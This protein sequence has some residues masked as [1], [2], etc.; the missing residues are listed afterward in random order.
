MKI[1]VPKEN[2]P[3]E[4]RVAAT[5][6]TV[7]KMVAR[8]WE[9]WVE[10]GAGAKAHFLNQAYEEAGAQVATQPSGT[11]DAWSSAGAVLKVGPFDSEGDRLEDLSAGTLVI[12]LLAPYRELNMVRQL[13]AGR[14]TSLAMELVPRITRAQ[15]MDALSSQASIAGYKAALLAASRLDR[16]FPLLMTAA[17]TVPPARVVVMGGGVAGLQ[18]VATAKRLGAVVEVSD[19]RPA[20]QQEVESLGGRFIELPELETGEGEGGYAKAMGEEFLR[21]QREIVKR[22][23]AAADVVI[24]TAQVPGKKAPMLVTRD[25]VEAMRPGAL[26]IDM[27]AENGGN[28]ELTQLGSEIVHEG[29]HILDPGNLP[30]AMA[31]D[32]SVLYARN[33]WGLLELCVDDNG[34]LEIDRQDE[35]IAGALLTHG[36]EVV[37]ADTAAKLQEARN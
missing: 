7:T 27:A 25:M 37:H 34:G 11:A 20:V 4:A 19:I 18:A 1:F 10:D 35:I 26:I 30:A 23:V 13:A 21:R 9:V 6:E 16:Y 15:S 32:A 5:P 22:H 28:C 14:V 2:G 17:G 8:G 24:T 31:H 3:E 33:V 12:G 36:G 29:V